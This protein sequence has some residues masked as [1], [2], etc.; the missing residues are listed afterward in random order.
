MTD[1]RLLKELARVAREQRTTEPDPRWDR[2]AAG[3]LS[4]D[5]VARLRDEAAR[6][7]EAAAAWE[8]F[9]PLEPELSR[10]IVEQARR[11]LPATPQAIPTA[12]PLSW[13]PRR[14]RRAFVPAL[15]A[16]ALIVLLSPWRNGPPLPPYDL[17]LE[18]AVRVERSGE[19]A[20]PS[21]PATFAPGNRFEL[22]LTPATSAGN[23]VEARVF[24]VDG[25]RVEL[26]QA[27]PPARS[28]DGALRIVG[29]VGQ[30]VRLPDG[31]FHLLVAVGR[32]G[33]LP[34]GTELRDHL[35][36]SDRVVEG[37]W[38]GWRLELRTTA[39]P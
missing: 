10:E 11:H 5:E 8:L 21:G 9:R 32:P 2:L 12:V 3:E 19:P 25:P 17:R 24:V 33:S 18:G 16:A 28:S 27:P 7:P 6:S 31:A 37:R 4:A 1:D 38:S 22:R 30:D 35:A 26:L 13:K 14:W 20:S 23:D 39:T 36:G 29:V 34:S 15:A